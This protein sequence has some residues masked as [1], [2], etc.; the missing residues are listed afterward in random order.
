MR[1]DARVRVL[2]RSHKTKL[3]LMGEDG[4]T[5]KRG[6]AR[7]FSSGYEAI[8]LMVAKGLEDGELVLDFGEPQLDLVLPLLTPA[9]GPRLDAGTFGLP[10][11]QRG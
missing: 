2:L 1:E 5:A 8:R 6:L 7:N 10:G 4:W 9:S 11:E 3:F